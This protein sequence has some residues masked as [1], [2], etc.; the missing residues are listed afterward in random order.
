MSIDVSKIP[1]KEIFYSV[2]TAIS[3]AYAFVSKTVAKYQPEIAAIIK[4]VEADSADGWTKE[5]KLELF[6]E[7][8]DEKVWP[9]LPWYIKILGHTFVENKIEEWTN[10]VIAKA[11][12]M[13]TK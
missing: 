11:F 3:A 6:W 9:I 8:F 12:E 10:K 2:V 1:V 4:R 7:L 5:E 13:K